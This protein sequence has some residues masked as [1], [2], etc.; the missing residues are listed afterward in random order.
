[1]NERKSQTSDRRDLDPQLMMSIVRNIPPNPHT[2][3]VDMADI[4][5][6]MS[7]NPSDM[8]KLLAHMDS[9]GFDNDLDLTNYDFAA[10]ASTIKRGTSWVIQLESTGMVDSSGRIAETSMAHN[11]PGLRPT[12]TVYCYDQGGRYRVMNDCIGLP[13]S[14]AVLE[15]LQRA[16][17]RPIQ[18]LKPAL[19]WFLLVSIKFQQHL[20]TLRPFLDSLPAPFHWRLETREEANELHES[21]F[22]ENERNAKLA[23]EQAE[24]CKAAGNEAFSRKDRKAALDAYSEAIECLIDALSQ[25]LDLE[26]ERK[27]KRQL[28]ICHGNR[29]AASLLEGS[30]M[31]AAKAIEDGKT[32]ERFD[33]SYAKAY[34]RQA[35]ANQALGK[36][37]DAQDA[38]VRA[39]RLKELQDDKGLV[40]RLIEIQTGGK[41]LSED[42]VLFRSWFSEVSKSERMAGIGGEWPRRCQA[43]LE[44]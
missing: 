44:K 12:F 38:I 43:W 17:A 9:V 8:E 30:G 36:S 21:V 14:Q 39:L 25:K 19:P 20:P 10:L 16:I 35:T 34:V 18:P 3:R 23:F 33:P 42:K 37:D 40:D 22:Q 26:E 24:R 5:K 11:I 7:K 1:M 27:A 2:G 6:Y 28:A 15:S 13:D 32:A 41:G 29:A 31:D 4:M